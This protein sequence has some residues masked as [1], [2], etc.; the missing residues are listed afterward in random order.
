MRQERTSLDPTR[1]SFESRELQTA[2]GA[3]LSARKRQFAPWS[4]CIRCFA[5]G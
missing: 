3:A 4:T 2:I 1:H 5:P